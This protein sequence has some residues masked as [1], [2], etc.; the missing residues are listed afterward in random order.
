MMHPRD[1]RIEKP[2]VSASLLEDQLLENKGSRS[3]E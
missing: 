1:C 3:Y 2:D